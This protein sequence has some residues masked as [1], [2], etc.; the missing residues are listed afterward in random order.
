MVGPPPPEL[1]L[2]MPARRPYRVPLVLDTLL[3]V[4]T[5][6]SLPCT[7][8]QTTSSTSGGST[9]PSKARKPRAPSPWGPLTRA[10]G[11]S[12][13]RSA[14]APCHRVNAPSAAA[15]ATS[16]SRTTAATRCARSAGGRTTP[17]PPGSQAMGFPVPTASASPRAGRTS[18]RGVSPRTTGL[19][20]RPARATRYRRNTRRAAKAD[21]DLVAECSRFE[22][23]MTWLDNSH[24]T[25]SPPPTARVGA[26]WPAIRTESCPRVASAV[27]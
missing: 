27:G 11:Q 26:D 10:G 3:R 1:T 14:A 15:A 25:V 2:P 24:L 5:T 12:P 4:P 13:R 8:R 18:R 16:R 7:D 22:L 9:S 17:P 6:A 19:S 21:H 20:F 23:L